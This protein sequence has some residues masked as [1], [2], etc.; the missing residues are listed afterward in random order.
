MRRALAHGQL[1]ILPWRCGPRRARFPA[2]TEA[3]CRACMHLVLPDGRIVTGADAAPE[4]RR[5]ITGWR[6]L[7][8]VLPTPVMRRLAT[9]MADRHLGLRCPAS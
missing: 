7:A 6:W 1:E 8:R 4:L 3:A 2:I 5:R 9:S